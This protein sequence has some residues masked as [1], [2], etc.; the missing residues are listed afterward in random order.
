M[1]VKYFFI[2]C[3]IE[4]KRLSEQIDTIALLYLFEWAHSTPIILVLRKWDSLNFQD[5]VTIL[6]SYIL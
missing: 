1:T 4:N 3:K 5:A 6:Y 2:F